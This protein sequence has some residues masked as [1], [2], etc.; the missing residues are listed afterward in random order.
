MAA[1]QQHQAPAV[2]HVGSQ[3]VPIQGKA[4]H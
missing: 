4:H 3:A 2:W 1:G